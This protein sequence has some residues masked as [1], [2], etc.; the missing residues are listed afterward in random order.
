M[1][2][3]K[4]MQTLPL[5]IYELWTTVV[6]YPFVVVS[7]VLFA[8]ALHRLANRYHCYGLPKNLLFAA[9]IGAFAYGFVQVYFFLNSHYGLRSL[10]LVEIIVGF[11]TA[12]LFTLIRRMVFSQRAP[13]ATPLAE[14]AAAESRTRE[15]L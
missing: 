6:R 4:T 1:G 10:I 9:V 2:D 12:V 15:Q 14:N 3:K 11:M 13:K 7:T 8:I 5:A